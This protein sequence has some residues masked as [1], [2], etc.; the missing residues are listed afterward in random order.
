MGALRHRTTRCGIVFIPVRSG[1]IHS[2]GLPHHLRSPSSRA[3]IFG[4][5][6]FDPSAVA[7]PPIE[8]AVA[9]HDSKQPRAFCVAKPH[10]KSRARDELDVFG[11]FHFVALEESEDV[12][13]APNHALPGMRVEEEFHLREIYPLQAWQIAAH[14]AMPA[15]ACQQRECVLGLTWEEIRVAEEMHSKSRR[16]TSRSRRQGSS[17]RTKNHHSSSQR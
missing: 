2:F 17:W 4:E 9:R 1:I 13:G 6:C 12:G 14:E 15:R 5:P 10:L 8:G 16:K 11:P 7:I 3:G